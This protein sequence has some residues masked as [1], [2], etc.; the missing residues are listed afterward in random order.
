MKPSVAPCWTISLQRISDWASTTTDGCEGRPRRQ[1]DF[2]H[3]GLSGKRPCPNR[4]RRRHARRSTPRI[5]GSGRGRVSGGRDEYSSSPSGAADRGGG[6]RGR[7]GEDRL[8][9]DCALVS[10]S[11]RSALISKEGFHARPHRANLDW[12]L[13]KDV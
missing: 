1:R 6:L 13:L 9:Q 5:G 12:K 10:G 8:S 4:D 3:C 7:F 11:V 2:R